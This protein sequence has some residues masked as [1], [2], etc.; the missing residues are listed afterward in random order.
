MNKLN[1][2][3]KHYSESA[4]NSCT[5]NKLYVPLIKLQGHISLHLEM[6]LLSG[7]PSSL[8]HN[9]QCTSSLVRSSIRSHCLTI[10][11]KLLVKEMVSLNNL[12]IIKII[13]IIVGLCGFNRKPAILLL[14]TS[15]AH[16]E[17]I[18]QNLGGIECLSHR[19][20]FH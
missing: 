5:Q 11:L 6:H 14:L 12:L 3:N 15:L 10:S 2:I 8:A 17:I 13:C 4:P 18:K 19:S 20:Q 1:A 16:H 9:L 7:L